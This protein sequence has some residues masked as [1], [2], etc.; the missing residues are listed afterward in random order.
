MFPGKK[1]FVP[2]DHVKSLRRQDTRIKS[3]QR[4]LPKYPDTMIVKIL[5][6]SASFDGV[7]YNTDK[8]DNGKGELMMVKNFGALQGLMN[9]RPEDY[10]NYL[11]MVSATNKAVKKPQFHVA[12]SAEGRSYD[13]HQLTEIA[14]KWL[15]KMGYG[16]QPYLI[17]F[18]KD[19]S[20]NHV[21]LVTTRVNRQGKKINSGF[22]KIR[23]QHNMNLVL[24][25]DEKYTAQTA[26]EKALSYSFTTKA[27]FMMILE[28]QGYKL[29]EKDDQL[30]V[31]KYGKVQGKVSLVAITEK[32]QKVAGNEK[33]IRQVSALFYKYAPQFDTTG[34]TEY[35]KEKH[36]IVLLFHSK[37]GKKPYGYTVIDHAG[38]AVYK[39]GEIM[40][41]S[42]LFELNA[43][44][45]SQQKKESNPYR[46]P[47]FEPFRRDYYRAMLKAAMENY[48][49]IRQGLQQTGIYIFSR[50]DRYY[51]V[52]KADKAFVPLDQLLDPAE[53]N[54]VMQ[55]FAAS[56]EVSAE[57]S[58]QH[59]YVPA[60][61]IAPSVDDEAMHGRKRRR[62]K[63]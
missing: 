7:D 59:I 14:E 36:G 12:I 33:R 30:N 21:H 15:G 29:A 53:Y 55:A 56:G 26:I 61:M 24:G 1:Y 60:P 45:A 8:I 49:D 9:L 2:G 57:I 43:G 38:K 25:L 35:L 18:H 62:K 16:E 40:P 4:Q 17:V 52:D 5:S 63:N 47:I 46:E 42:K 50:D 19:T 27:Q 11:K 34:L 13:K 48:P 23:A 41:L 32:M 37:G 3:I 20:N 39:G 58:K 10:K 22:E 28:C 54:E 51:L 44:T 6:S 31:I